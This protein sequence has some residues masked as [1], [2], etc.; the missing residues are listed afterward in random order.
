MLGVYI[1][2]WASKPVKFLIV[3]HLYKNSKDFDKTPKE[4]FPHSQKEKKLQKIKQ[5]CIF[6]KI[7][8]TIGNGTI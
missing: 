1:C 2:T 3:L 5:K 6:R 4:K 7:G 8:K